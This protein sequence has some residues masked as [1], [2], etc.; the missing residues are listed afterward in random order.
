MLDL[1]L[2]IFLPLVFLFLVSSTSLFAQKDTLTIYTLKGCEQCARAI[3]FAE[4][5]K[6]PYK[7]FYNEDVNHHNQL[8]VILEKEGFKTGKL[9]FPVIIYKGKTHFNFPDLNALLKSFDDK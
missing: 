1:V 5:Q 2:K 8:A 6:L 4:D 9:T 3:K 7:V